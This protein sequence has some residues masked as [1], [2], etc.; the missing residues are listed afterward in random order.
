MVKS[1]YKRKDNLDNMADY[2]IALAF[3][4]SSYAHIFFKNSTQSIYLFF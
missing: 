4:Y 1:F 2:S 3:F